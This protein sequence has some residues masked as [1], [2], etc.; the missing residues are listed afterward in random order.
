MNLSQIV[1]S[2][3]TQ[4]KIPRPFP[5]CWVRG[6][7]PA[8]LSELMSCP[9]PLTYTRT[10]LL[11]C[12]RSNSPYL[13]AFARAGHLISVRLP[14]S[15]PSGLCSNAS[16]PGS[17]PWPPQ[18]KQ[19]LPP[20]PSYLPYYSFQL[21]PYIFLQELFINMKIC[22]LAVSPIREW[23]FSGVCALLNFQCMQQC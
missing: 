15:H 17:L 21:S 11:A 22:L 2:Q 19:P 23:A 14:L 6:P 12:N 16:P 18:L 3:L 1:A 13:R 20:L 10:S 9:I 4:N 8:H 7:G 5:A